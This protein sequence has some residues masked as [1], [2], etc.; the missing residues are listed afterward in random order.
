MIAGQ[1]TVGLE[2]AEDVPDADL[3]VLP[4]GGGGLVA[5]IATAV[6]ARPES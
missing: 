5:G 1:G 4:V 6:K 3:I 2:I